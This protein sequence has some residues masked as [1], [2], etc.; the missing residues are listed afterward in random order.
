MSDDG[1]YKTNKTIKLFLK[2]QVNELIRV[3]VISKRVKEY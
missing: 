2:K 1:G 3:K